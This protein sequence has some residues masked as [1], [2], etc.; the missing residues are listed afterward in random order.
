MFSSK[1]P[2]GF[3]GLNVQ[4]TRKK[5]SYDWRKT[6][7]KLKENGY[8]FEPTKRVHQNENTSVVESRKFFSIALT[9]RCV[10]F[11]SRLLRLRNVCRY[12]EHGFNRTGEIVR[13]KFILYFIEIKIDFHCFEKNCTNDW[14][15]MQ[16]T[17]IAYNFGRRESNPKP[18]SSYTLSLNPSPTYLP[19]QGLMKKNRYNT[20]KHLNILYC[21]RL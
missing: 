20:H 15:K 18:H 16:K 7:V 2:K 9:I 6:A 1:T 13:L 3:Y 17:L 4:Y 12:N 14:I 21:L 19:K 10:F 5:V 8:D 11:K